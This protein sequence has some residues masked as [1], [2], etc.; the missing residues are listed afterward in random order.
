MTRE[1]ETTVKWY[2]IHI[3][4]IIAN[5]KQIKCKQQKKNYKLQLKFVFF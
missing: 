4:F 3:T 1:I 2:I 5:E